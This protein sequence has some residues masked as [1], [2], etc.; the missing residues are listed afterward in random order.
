M[1]EAVQQEVGLGCDT[2]GALDCKD[3]MSPVWLWILDDKIIDPN[4]AS[5]GAGCEDVL[6]VEE[7]TITVR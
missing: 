5:Y 2:V 4:D 7:F 3:G 1:A 6:K